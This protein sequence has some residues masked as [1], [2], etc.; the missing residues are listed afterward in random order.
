MSGH[1]WCQVTNNGT[2][3]TDGIGNHGNNEACTVMA[4]TP[5]FATTTYFNTEG[6]FDYITIGGQRYSGFGTNNGFANVQVS[7]RVRNNETFRALG[8]RR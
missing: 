2:C 8:I 5:L 3:V 7:R 4:M 6:Y 1:Q